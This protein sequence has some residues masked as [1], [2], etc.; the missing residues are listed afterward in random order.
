MPEVRPRTIG[1][2]EAALGSLASSSKIADAV[3]ELKDRFLARTT[4]GPVL[5]KRKTL[6]RI[7]RAAGLDPLPLE[8][9]NLVV[10]AAPL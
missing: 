4:K 1:N 9:A 5:A 3:E 2:L 8:E 10:G 6:T 7:L